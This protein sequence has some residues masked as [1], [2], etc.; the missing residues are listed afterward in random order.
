MKTKN[1]FALGHK[2]PA[3]VKAFSRQEIDSKQFTA[4][5]SSI[6]RILTK[7]AESLEGIFKDPDNFVKGRAYSFKNIHN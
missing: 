2:I 3:Q 7:W 6:L 1:E 4:R 5:H